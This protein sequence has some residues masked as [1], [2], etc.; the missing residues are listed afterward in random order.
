[1][2]GPAC[3][4]AVAAGLLAGCGPMTPERAA[5]LCEARAQQAAG[6][7]GRIE[8]GAS[9]RSGPFVGGEI[10]ITTDALLGRDPLAVYE[11]CV[12]DRTG[13]APIRPP[14]LPRGYYL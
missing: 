13:Q 5:D 14:S 6:P 7:T 2:R 3:I 4:L 8:I 12:F 11:S 1:M 9:N 10:D